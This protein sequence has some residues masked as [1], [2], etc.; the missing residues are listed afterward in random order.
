MDRSGADARPRS[1]YCAIKVRHLVVSRARA[2]LSSRRQMKWSNCFA[3]P[4]G[5]RADVF[6]AAVAGGGQHHHP[7]SVPALAGMPPATRLS[8]KVHIASTAASGCARS[9]G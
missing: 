2:R 6:V 3:A 4:R 9:R 8:T 5:E 1:R 7:L